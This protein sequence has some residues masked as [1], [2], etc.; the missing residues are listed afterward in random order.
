M[1][2]FTHGVPLALGAGLILTSAAAL[3]NHAAQG[4][5]GV[6]EEVA[7]DVNGAR[8]AVDKNGKLRAPT[9]EEAAA[10]LQAVSK[11]T[12]QSAEGL[13][14]VTLPDGTKTVDL[15]DR[16]QSVSLARV[17]GG[18][19][20]TTCVGTQ[21]EAKAFLESKAPKAKAKKAKKAAAAKEVK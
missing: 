10:L 20:V 1:I 8:V 16:F 21:A 5:R 18:Q 14:V 17:Q 6:D 12:N 3:A 11:Y 15:Q 2:R 7:V 9:P 13:Q 19:V 4:N